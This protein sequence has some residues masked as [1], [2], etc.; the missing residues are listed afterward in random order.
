MNGEEIASYASV[1]LFL[2]RAKTSSPGF[3]PTGETLAAIAGICRRLDGLPLAIELAAARCNV[4]PPVAMRARMEE[5]L[6]LLTQ[7]P[8]DAPERLQTMRGAIAWSYHLLA[9]DEQALLRRLAVFAGGF[10]LD[11]AE[12]VAEPALPETSPVWGFGANGDAAGAHGSRFTGLLLD[13]ITALV[14]Q[15]LIQPDFAFA[16]E[17]RF[18]VLATIQE[19]ALEQ[20]R[21][22]G[23]EPAARQAHAAYFRTYVTTLACPTA[24]DAPTHREW[25][26]RLDPEMANIRA[27]LTW[28]VDQPDPTPFFDMVTHLPGALAGRIGHQE[29]RAWLARAVARSASL[30]TITRVRVLLAAKP[31]VRIEHE[32]EEAMAQL[33]EALALAREL[34]DRDEELTA[35]CWLANI[36]WRSGDFIA[37]KAFTGEAL[38]FE[39]AREMHDRIGKSLFELGVIAFFAGDLDE[40]A[41][42]FEEALPLCRAVRFELD[43]GMVLSSLAWVRIEQGRYDEAATLLRESIELNWSIRHLSQLTWCFSFAA[44]IAAGLGEPAAAARLFGVEAALRER[45]QVPVPLLE[46]DMYERAVGTVRAALAPDAFAAAWAAGA[47]LPL[48]D[49]ITE[50]LATA[51]RH[52]VPAPAPAAASPF[53]GLT[54][55]EAEI[56]PFL[57]AGRTNGEIGELLCISP[58]TAGTHVASILAKLGLHSRRDVRAFSLRHGAPSPPS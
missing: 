45:E 6:P 43:T 2:A 22:H 26:N 42:R 3:A 47:A 30:R 55:R 17:P 51:D 31:F 20:L 10:C 37:A 28:L 14:D 5:R 25:L 23:E 36:A 9:P 50:A 44:R 40:A 12:A 7:G 58:R 27:A 48:D 34:G 52:A 8:R 54:A 39:R 11:A 56:V 13:R 21:G 1:R 15:S 33:R 24:S 53:A 46:R 35:L 49:A 29:G 32:A 41:A 57:V 38:A 19:F 16:G 4:L 18:H